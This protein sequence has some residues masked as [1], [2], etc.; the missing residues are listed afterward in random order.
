MQG[1]N[2]GGSIASRNIL[3]NKGCLKWCVRD[4]RKNPRIGAYL[5]EKS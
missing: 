5:D 4:R 3:E 2:M 1:M